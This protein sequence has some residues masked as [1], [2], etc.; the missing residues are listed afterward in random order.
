MPMIE[1]AAVLGAGSWGTA[2][3]IALGERGL[4]VVLYGNEP[5]V[6]DEINTRH[7]NETYLPGI[8][9]P[10]TV[11]ATLDLADVVSRPLILLVVPSK[12]AR[13]VLT[14]LRDAGLPADTILL[15]CTKGLD[16]ETG[17][18]MHD[19]ISELLPANPVAVLSGP[20]HA[21]EVAARLAT[22]AVIGCRDE[23]TAAR[24]QEVFTLPWFRTYTSDDLIGIEIGGVVKNVFAIAAGI[25]DGLGLGDNAKAGMVTRG[26]AEMTRLGEALGAKPETLRGL[27]GVGD[28]IVTCYSAHSRNNRV[29]RLL[30][31]GKTLEEAVAAL[32]QVAEGVPNA[33]SVHHLA[34]KL[35]VRTPLI[36]QVH[37]VL[38][39]NKPTRRALQEL[40][41]RDPR[42]END[43]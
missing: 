33:K 6:V 14:Q 25:V 2:L 42:A 17:Q 29:G 11:S 38:Y 8:T 21:E 41:N 34:R 18:L 22:A 23:P 5:Q 24:I 27:S 30:G 12:V 31:Q 10:P 37:A 36:D 40:L 16:P 13:L 1:Q 3:S 26:L 9:L 32:N 19:L 35:N 39:E 15:T 7:T 28:L 20:T 43:D 4:D